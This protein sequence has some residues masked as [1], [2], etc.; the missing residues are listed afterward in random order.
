[1]AMLDC[2]PLTEH[3]GYLVQSQMRLVVMEMYELDLKV[4]ERVPNFL[5]KNVDLL[6]SKRKALA[7]SPFIT[8]EQFATFALKY[9]EFM[10]PAYSLQEEV[11]R[12][13]PHAVSGG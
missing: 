3:L 7:L 9:P 8:I 13:A 4:D 5:L 6:F 12:L 10:F 2:S 11:G 1:M